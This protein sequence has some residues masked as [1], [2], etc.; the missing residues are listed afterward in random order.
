MSMKI[1]FETDNEAFQDGEREQEC[2]D[3]LRVIIELVLGGKTSGKLMDRHGNRIGH[4]N[5][6]EGDE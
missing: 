6:E 2:A 3:T 5:L 4:W 1:E